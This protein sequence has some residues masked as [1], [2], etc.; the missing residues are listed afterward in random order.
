MYILIALLF[1]GAIL[2]V[3][4]L[5]RALGGG[6]ESQVLLEWV[7]APMNYIL[8]PSGDPHSWNFP[9]G[10]GFDQIFSNIV[11]RIMVL[12]FGEENTLAIRFPALIAGIAC[13]WMVYKLTRQISSSKEMGQ[14]AL[15]L[16]SV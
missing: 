9:S 3:H 14:L 2:R 13:I 16:V 10:Y 4:H 5:G 6:D 11:L 15:I 8:T 12:L 1:F 7:Y